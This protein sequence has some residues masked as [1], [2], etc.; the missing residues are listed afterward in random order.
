[1]TGPNHIVGGT[2]FTGLFCS[3]WNVNI[4]ANP[5][6][7]VATLF[8]S[9]L[10]DIDHKRSPMGT[11]FSFTG[12]PQYLDRNYGHR[13][14]THSLFLY[15]PLGLLIS[16]AES[17]LNTERV[18]TIIYFLAYG[19]HL[20]FDMMTV[21]GVPLLFPY[22]KNPC[23]LPANKE[24]RL[25]VADYKSEALIFVLFLGLGLFCYPLMK[26]GFWTSYNRTFGTLE[27]LHKE[28][29]VSQ[30][31]LK[32]EY[33]FIAKGV[34]RKGAG[35][36][37]TSEG[38]KALI[39]DENELFEINKNMKIIKITPEHT[40]LKWKEKEVYFY[41]INE[42]SIN[43]MLA[44]KIILNTDFQC[45]HKAIYWDGKNHKESNVI[46]LKN[47]YSPSLEINTDTVNEKAIKQLEIKKIELRTKVM[48]AAKEKEDYRSILN[49]IRVINNNYE[50]MS[51][52]EKESAV[53]RLKTLNR[54]KVDFSFS[55]LNLDKINKEIEQLEE[56]IV[57]VDKVQFTG[58][59]IY[60]EYEI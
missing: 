46:K 52:S 60:F 29:V 30:D 49:G 43:D 23:V 33:D 13:T 6:Y 41:S 15:V 45:S 56:E 32:V 24:F 55:I 57:K 48:H 59:I 44:D 54:K 9:I 38:S 14:I 11:V 25:K 2:V 50:S 31:L 58:K 27:H 10:A 35:I 34:H 8:F 36:V 12:L 18:Y 20:I 51:I 17:F 53:N 42:D 22:K 3:F 16:V 19:S 47:S 21:S 4:F 26:N 39:F 37:I 5:W 28:H 40:G 7:I 1:M